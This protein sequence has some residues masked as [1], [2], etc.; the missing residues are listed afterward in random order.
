MR[1]Y[2]SVILDDGGLA[3][4]ALPLVVLL[5]PHRRLVALRGD[6]LQG[7]LR[8]I[9]PLLGWPTDAP[10]R[11]QASHSEGSAAG[12]RSDRVVR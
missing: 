8:L 6:G 2:R 7:L 3:D 11:D 4:V 9:V 12:G 5:A 10:R 1:G